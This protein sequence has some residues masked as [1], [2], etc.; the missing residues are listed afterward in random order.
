MTTATYSSGMA[1]L[2]GRYD[3]E[4]AQADSALQAARQAA[5]RQYETDQDEAKASYDLAVTIAKAEHRDARRAARARFFL[6]GKR[7]PEPHLSPLPHEPRHGQTSAP[8]VSLPQ[9]S[10]VEREL[11]ELAALNG[12][13]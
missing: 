10:G 13:A 8:V 11:A 7:L 1:T 6:D 4:L 2:N 3:V 12:H 9:V 5:K